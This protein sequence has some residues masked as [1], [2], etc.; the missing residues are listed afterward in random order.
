VIKE[1]Q[2]DNSRVE[3]HWKVWNKMLNFCDIVWSSSWDGMRRLGWG[4]RASPS[5]IVSICNFFL[6]FEPSECVN[7]G[8]QKLDEKC[9]SKDNFYFIW[10][11]DWFWLQISFVRVQTQLARP[12]EQSYPVWVIDQ[13]SHVTL[14]CMVM[15]PEAIAAKMLSVFINQNSEL[16]ALAID[17]NQLVH[18]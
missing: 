18:P 16:R 5:N 9:S 13:R 3:L 6:S 15:V 14:S 8:G 17:F 11:T 7:F 10:M 12:A 2:P 4:G 1:S